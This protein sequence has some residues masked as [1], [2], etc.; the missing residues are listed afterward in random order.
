[1]YGDYT[2]YVSFIDDLPLFNKNSFI[3]LKSVQDRK[4]YEEFTETQIFNQLVQ[5]KCNEICFPYFYKES[6]RYINDQ[7]L[8]TTNPTILINMVE[9]FKLIKKGGDEVNSELLKTKSDK[10]FDIILIKPQYLEEFNEFKNSYKDYKKIEE[11]IFS[12]FPA[13]SNK[14]V[15]NSATNTN[16]IIGVNQIKFEIKKKVYQ[17]YKFELP[18]NIYC[19][20]SVLNNS[21][22]FIL[23]N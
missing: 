15:N 22:I 19:K 1:M 3:S 4:F 18:E 5:S 21:I 6:I 7:N 9:E 13:N 23:L 8:M 16:I 20:E 10:D 17:F 2:K 14:V 11:F 12:K